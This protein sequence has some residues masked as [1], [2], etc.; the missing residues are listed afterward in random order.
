[1]N[2]Y[3]IIDTYAGLAQWHGDYASAEDAMAHFDD[4]VGLRPNGGEWAA[5]QASDGAVYR[6]EN[7]SRARVLLPPRPRRLTHSL[8]E[9]HNDLRHSRE[10]IHLPAPPWLLV[11]RHRHRMG[12]YD[13]TAWAKMIREYGPMMGGVLPHEAC[14]II[15]ASKALLDMLARCG[16]HCG[17]G[18]VMLNG[19][20]CTVREAQD[21][22][23]ALEAA[24]NRTGLT[25][26]KSLA[27]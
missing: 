20:A 14:N 12:R 13:G 21:H 26:G 1:M 11:A 2:T 18:H 9:L 23:Y 3:T 27:F 19:V 6:V 24:H 5:T 4:A 7:A 15:P 22:R 25:L 16:G 17:T 8:G 10:W